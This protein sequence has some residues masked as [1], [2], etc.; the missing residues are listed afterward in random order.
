MVA[1]GADSTP[2]VT[3]N[4]QR[5]GEGT[6][7]PFVPQV[8]LPSTVPPDADSALRCPACA[9]VNEPCSSPALVTLVRR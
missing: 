5:M 1:P 7:R 2:M 9:P 3:V 6:R 8:V 4:A